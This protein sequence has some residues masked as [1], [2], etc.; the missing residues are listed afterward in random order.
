[1]RAAQAVLDRS[2]QAGQV[3]TLSGLPPV[4]A[5]IAAADADAEGELARYEKTVLNALRAKARA[6][7]VAAA[8]GSIGAE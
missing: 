4:R 6:S 3:L 1:M 7:S 8:T 2:R 5:R